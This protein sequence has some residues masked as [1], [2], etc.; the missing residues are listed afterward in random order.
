[1]K[2]KKIVIGVLVCLVVAGLS[3]WGGMKYGQSK[4][5]NFALNSR[6][7]GFNQN[8][9]AG[10]NSGRMGMRGSTGGG[11]VTGE[12]LSKDEK[13]MTIKIRDGG[14]KI[15][16]FS[17]TTKVEKTVDGTIVDASVGKQVTIV[18]TTNSDG[19]VVAT[20]IQMRPDTTLPMM[21]VKSN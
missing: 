13:S 7:G 8:L 4:N 2:N 10:Q 19:S 12:I 5:N 6:Q 9:V 20:S 3:F 11:F 16:F 17:P 1:M 18:G 21:Q 15:V 14:S